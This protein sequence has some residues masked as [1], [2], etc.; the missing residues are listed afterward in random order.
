MLY[1][2]TQLDKFTIVL[3]NFSY[4]EGACFIVN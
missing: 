2:V 3:T 1:S 4:I